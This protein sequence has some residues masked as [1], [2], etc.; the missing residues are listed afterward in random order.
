V[1]AG[2]ALN[3]QPLEARG[4]VTRPLRRALTLAAEALA[5]GLPVPQE[6]VDLAAKPL[7]PRWL[8]LLMAH[9]GWLAQ[10]WKRRTLFR[11]NARPFA[12]ARTNNK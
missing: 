1:G 8:Y 3:G 11:L 2:G 10:A 5:H 4:R 9:T 7:L 12:S 6:S